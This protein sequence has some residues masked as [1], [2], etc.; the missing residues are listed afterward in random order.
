MFVPCH[1]CQSEIL[2]GVHEHP[3][4]NRYVSEIIL[5]FFFYNKQDF[6]MAA[7]QQPDVTF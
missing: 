3:P 2:P 7:F 5:F 4:S 6:N 1:Y